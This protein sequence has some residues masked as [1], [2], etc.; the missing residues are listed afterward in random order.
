MS[1]QEV[2]KKFKKEIRA[3]NYALWIINWDSETEMPEGSHQY[4]ASQ[5]AV[6]NEKLFSLYLDPKRIEAL[7]NLNNSILEFPFKRE[8]ELEY[9]NL[10]KIIKVP[11]KELLKQQILLDKANQIYKKAKKE[12][13][14]SIFESTLEEIINYKKKYIKYL[15]TKD[16]KGYDVL[17]NDYHEGLKVEDY[18][19]Y[20]SLLKKELVPLIEKVNT[21]KLKYS[22]VLDKTLFPIN[23]QREFNHYLLNTLGYDLKHGLLKESIHPFTS[24]VTAKDVRITTTYYQNNLQSAIFSTIHEMG[25][26][27]YEQQTDEKY[28]G[29]ITEKI[30]SFAMHESQSR[31]YENMLGRSYEFWINHYK[32]L[33]E[34]F[35]EE[36]KGV[37]L[38]DFYKY[39]NKVENSFIRVNADEL[40][41][42][43]HIMIRYEIEK[44]I[45][46]ENLPISEIKPLWNKLYK[47]N[48]GLIVKN[49]KE[50]VLQDIHWSGG[51]FGYFPS[52]SLG[53]AIAAQLYNSMSKQI[54]VN[55]IILDNKI[56]II[57]KW[58]KEKI[59]KHGSFK[60]PNEI[61]KAATEEDFNPKYYLNYL[62]EKYSK[63]Y[64]IK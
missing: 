27:I 11:K 51:S 1:Y 57:N 59:H 49:D 53:S 55:K 24:G 33:T 17:L 60:T 43:I 42:S 39:I 50:G 62:I 54:D 34:I 4:K 37:S 48:L 19:K 29:S 22:D 5:R 21:K 3:L 16:L 25:H 32:K 44:A 2:Y 20:F 56:D 38:D 31:L 45:F 23:K 40:T 47:D 6:L 64:K 30:E 63:L 15:Q 7:E 14:F 28:I 26:A 9:K 12:N 46:N 58:L 52:Y 18:D 61:I 41:Y 10:L 36:L 13:D 35:N 8:I